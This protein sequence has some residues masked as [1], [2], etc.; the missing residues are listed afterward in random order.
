M[1]ISDVLQHNEQVE[2]RAYQYLLR[3]GLVQDEACIRCG[4]LCRN[5]TPPRSPG[6]SFKYR[7]IRCQINYN[8][9]SATALVGCKLRMSHI[10][11]LLYSFINNHSVKLAHRL[12]ED[13]M[14]SRI[15]KLT[16]RSWFRKFRRLVCRHINHEINNTVLPGP[17]EID[18]CMLF[19]SKRGYEDR[20]RPYR[21]HIWVFGLKC[22]T[23]KKFVLIPLRFR[24]RG[25][26]VQL[27]LKHVAHGAW[28]YT[29]CWSA[30]INNRS[31]ESYLEPWGYVHF[32]V[33]HSRHFVNPVIP[34]IHTNTI[35]R[36][37][38]TT[39]EFTRQNQPR[40]YFDE[41]LAIFY[42][43]KIYTREQRESMMNTWL[44]HLQPL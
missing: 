41:H 28:V 40:A 3:N 22:R 32:Y 23:T 11:F 27:I 9:F 17:V 35:E 36:L 44:R 37:W 6:Y 30:Y 4:L 43:N 8:S 24:T 13:F 7:C 21:N 10:V 26:I 34:S 15:S 1:N 14:P 12:L 25:I 42:W 38:R 31:R 2:G 18:E 19:R 39:R 20:A 16:V 29:D 33:N 5:S